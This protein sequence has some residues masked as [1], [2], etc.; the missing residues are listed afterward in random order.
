MVVI[1]QKPSNPGAFNKYYYEIHV[2]LAKKI[3]G[4]QTYAASQGPVVSV[5]GHEAYLVAILSFANMETLKEAFRSPEGQACAVDRQKL[6][7]NDQV[8]IFLFDENAL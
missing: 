7:T 6:A 1:Y 3:T 2:T 8:Q 4:L 5:T